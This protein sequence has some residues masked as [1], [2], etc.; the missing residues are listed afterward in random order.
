[1]TKLPYFITI[2]RRF[3]SKELDIE[4]LIKLKNHFAMAAELAKSISVEIPDMSEQFENLL[5]AY[6]SSKTYQAHKYF[7]S[8]NQE[9][10]SRWYLTYDRYNPVDLPPCVNHCLYNPNPH[11]LKPTN[12][13]TLVRVLMKKGWHP[14]HIAG[15]IR[16]KFER[17]YGWGS[18]WFKYDA[19]SRATTYTR[20]FASM[21]LAGV[22]MEIDLNCVSHKEKGYCFKP[23]CGFNLIN[24]KL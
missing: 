12:I 1:A 6:Y 5:R 23:F 14:M 8:Q 11:L 9:P 7:Y 18:E 24:Y 15:L 10:P 20:F 2:P 17:D 4:T 21:L 3:D 16:S 19:N 13:Q 22:D